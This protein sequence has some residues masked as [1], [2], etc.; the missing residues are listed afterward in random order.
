MLQ[1]CQPDNPCCTLKCDLPRLEEP[2]LAVEVVQ[3]GAGFEQ[4]ALRC[5]GAMKNVVADEVVSEGD[6]CHQR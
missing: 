4:M 6:V 5:Y 2:W 3:V 1:K